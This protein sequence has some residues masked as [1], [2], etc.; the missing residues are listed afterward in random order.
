M[1]NSLQHICWCYLLSIL[2]IKTIRRCQWTVTG[3]V[4]CD[5]WASLYVARRCAKA[6]LTPLLDFSSTSHQFSPNSLQIC[7]SG[8]KRSNFRSM[9]IFR[10]NER[11]TLSTLPGNHLCVYYSSK[12]E[13]SGTIK[14][15]KFAFFTLSISMVTIKSHEEVAEMR[16]GG[17]IRLG[18]RFRCC[19]R[20]SKGEY[21]RT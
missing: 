13:F 5:L 7:S 10:E 11:K 12:E 6:Q 4:N 1:L 19:G 2:F 9:L 16:K 18:F 3:L 21:E 15:H 14:I 17:A 20:A 8:T